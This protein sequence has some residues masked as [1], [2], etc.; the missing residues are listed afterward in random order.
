M[1]GFQKPQQGAMLNTRINSRFD[2][3]EMLSTRLQ[4][5]RSARAASH[6]HQHVGHPRL[7]KGLAV[8]Q[9]ASKTEHS[10]CDAKLIPLMQTENL[11]NQIVE[12]S[13]GLKPYHRFWWMSNPGNLLALLPQLKPRICQG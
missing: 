2:D 8:T 10:R 5:N 9:R 3:G 12:I 7:Q 1:N 11:K 4:S 6:L 13:S